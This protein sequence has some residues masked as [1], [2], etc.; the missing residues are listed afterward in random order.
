MFAEPAF[1]Q[2]IA[3]FYPFTGG[4]QV[5]PDFI[6][7]H[8]PTGFER[9]GRGGDFRGGAVIVS[10][11][12]RGNLRQRFI[13]TVPRRILSDKHYLR[14]SHWL[15]LIIGIVQI[16]VALAVMRAASLGARPGAVDRVPD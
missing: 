4:D 2:S 12:D 6:T 14:V 8:M 5:F 11:L 1:A 15:T 7:K 3:N 13:Q 10:E 16:V 9:I